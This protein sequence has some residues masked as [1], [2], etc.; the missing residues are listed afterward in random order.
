MIVLK[1][2]KGDDERMWIIG[3]NSFLNRKTIR[4]KLF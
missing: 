2:I 1:I 4:Q 3:L